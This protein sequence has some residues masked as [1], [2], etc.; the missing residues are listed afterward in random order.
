MFL[1]YGSLVGHNYGWLYMYVML[2]IY[3]LAM[4]FKASVILAADMS[5]LDV[6]CKGQICVIL[7]F[8]VH[9]MEQTVLGRW[10]TRVDGAH[11]AWIGLFMKI[12]I[13]TH[14]FKLLSY[15]VLYFI[16]INKLFKIDESRTQKLT[17]NFVF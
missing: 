13:L 12:K 11:P 7:I 15:T 2:E 5:D 4:C 6:V 9:F 16:L 1:I 14:I 10:W 3:F 8:N 17:V